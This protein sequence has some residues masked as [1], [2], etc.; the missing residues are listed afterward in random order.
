MF[1]YL[2]EVIETGEQ[3]LCEE[4]TYEQALKTLSLYFKPYEL[5][6]IERFSV[7]EGEMMGLDTY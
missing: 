1:D 2:F 7:E 5:E 3:I 4:P 6:F